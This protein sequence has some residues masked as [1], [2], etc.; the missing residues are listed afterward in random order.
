MSY[1]IIAVSLSNRTSESYTYTFNHKTV[2][3]IYYS[4]PVSLFAPI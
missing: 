3:S 2:F 1:E 4:N